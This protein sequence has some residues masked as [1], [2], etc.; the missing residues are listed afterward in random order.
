MNGFRLLLLT[1]AVLLLAASPA[2]AQDSTS[3]PN[4]V[5]M[6][7]LGRGLLY[8]GNYERHFNRFGVGGGVSVWGFDGS[9]AVI[10]P[11]YASYRPV[12]NTNSL[13]VAG[14]ATVGSEAR[15]FFN[16]PLTVGTIAVGF[17]HR[18]NSGLVIRPTVTYAFDRDDWVLWPGLLV[19]FRF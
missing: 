17:E 9:T 3:R 1:S 12:G 10:V 4:L 6:E 15:T 2:A 19:G 7:I 18:S 14:G 16:R 5:G 11:M 8:S 13:Y